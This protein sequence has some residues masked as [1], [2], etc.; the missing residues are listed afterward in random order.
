[1]SAI[2]S[3]VTCDLANVADADRF[4]AVLLA[5]RDRCL[6]DEPG[7]LQFDILRPEDTEGKFMI[8]EV[9]ANEAA[10]KAHSEGNSKKQGH[11]ELEGI[12]YK[13]VSTKYFRLD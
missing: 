1:M 13:A 9:F 4:Q 8:Y 10:L 5:H 6:R 3:V 11:A 2:A 7:T 12:Q